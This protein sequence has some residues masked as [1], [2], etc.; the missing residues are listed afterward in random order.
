MET[1]NNLFCECV[2]AAAAWTEINRITGLDISITKFTDVAELWNNS[3]KYKVIN[4]VHAALLRVLW[5]VRNDLCSNPAVRPGMQVIW[6]RTAYMLAQWGILL[7]E[8][9]RRDLNQMVACLEVLAHAPPLLLWP[10][11]G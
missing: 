7:P 5:L 2:V 9:E 10:E 4:M 11:P 8:A 6:R 3:K 1:C